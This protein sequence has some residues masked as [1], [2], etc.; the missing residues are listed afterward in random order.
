MPH[1][2]TSVYDVG[3]TANLAMRRASAERERKQKLDVVLRDR[4]RRQEASV[5]FENQPEEGHFSYEDE[6]LKKLQNAEIYRPPPRRMSDM[7]DAKKLKD[8]DDVER[9]NYEQIRRAREQMAEEERL[10]KQP[11]AVIR[12]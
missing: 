7:S 9:R 6:G 10:K 8:D 3:S 2:P 11:R 1:K 4:R 5:E 12:R